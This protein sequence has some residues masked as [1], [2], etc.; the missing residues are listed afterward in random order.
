MSGKPLVCIKENAAPIRPYLQSLAREIKRPDY[1]ML[2]YRTKPG[3]I[4]YEGPSNDR[5]KIYV[6]AAT[7]ATLGVVSGAALG[8][9]AASS[10]AAG[11]AS[12][13]G[14][15][16]VAAGTALSAGTVSAALTS[17][18]PDPNRDS[19]THESKSEVLSELKSKTTS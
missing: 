13:G 5:T 9:V 19:Y 14:A 4:P 6:F 18:Q 12:S 11:G 10:A 17:S 3:E 7:I 8:A 1:R 15:G 2:D 16:L